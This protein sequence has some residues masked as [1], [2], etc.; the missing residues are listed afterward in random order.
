MTATVSERVGTSPQFVDVSPYF[1]LSHLPIA[2]P[3]SARSPLECLQGA[4]MDLLERENQ[5]SVLD[6]ALSDTR[7]GH[8]R[9]A[10]VSGEAGIGKTALLRAFLQGID[11]DGPRTPRILRGACENLSVAEPLAPLY[12]LSRDVGWQPPASLSGGEGRLALFSDA[13]SEFSSWAP[14]TILVIEDLHWADEATLDFVRFLAR[15]I[16]DHPILFLATA[17]NDGSDAQAQL[18]RA[19]GEVPP[20]ALLRVG[21]PPLSK[22]AVDSLARAAGRDA[23]AV[24]D[25]TKGNAFFVTELLHAEGDAP[26]PSVQDAVLARAE[27]LSEPARAVLD[28]ASVFPRRA[29]TGLVADIIGEAAEEGIEECLDRGLLDLDGSDLLFRHELARIA[30]EGALRTP[31]RRRLNSDLYSFLTEAGAPAARRL[32]HAREAGLNEVVRDLAPRAAEAAQALGARREAAA[33]YRVSVNAVGEDASLDLLETA[34][35]ANYYVGRYDAAVEYQLRVQDGLAGSNDPIREGDGLRRL[36]RFLWTGGRQVDAREYAERAVAHL[37]GLE[38]GELAHALSNLSQLMMLSSF[39]EDAV[40]ASEKAIELAKRFDRPDVVA[41]AL[42][43][44]GGARIFTNMEFA[45]R[46]IR[47]S[48]ELSLG[49]GAAD[50]AARAMCN[51]AYVEWW[52][53][54]YS[55]GYD[56]STGYLD[57]MAEQELDGYFDYHGGT[58]ALF[59]VELA[60]FEEAERLIAKTTAPDDETLHGWH[61]FPGTVANVRYRMRRGQP[62][63]PVA[64]RYLEIFRERATESQRFAPLT[65]L[66]AERVWI[67]GGD[68]GPIIEKMV[69]VIA[70]TLRPESIPYMRVWLHRFGAGDR[71]CE[72][73]DLVPV[74]HRK[75]MEGDHLGAAA[76][77]A[78]RNAPYNEAF[79]L[80]FSG[81]SEKVREAAAIFERLGAA[82]HAK[83]ALREIGADGTA[84]TAASADPDALTRRQMD[85]LRCLTEGKSNAQIGEALFISSKTVDHHVS[86]ILA[87]LGAANR[88]EAAAIARDR[89]LV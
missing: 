71:D 68:T 81:I 10:L 54:N 19:L 78:D 28:A 23:G 40:P 33:H 16:A 66:E 65:E 12:D 24:W 51:V 13:L 36:S 15:R 80:A 32:H 3:Y 55:E 67:E 41:H 42:N 69:D 44:L 62:S 77:W 89:G 74:A 2:V 31:R 14:G 37:E 48:I 17:R 7:A 76:I 84:R 50:E 22:E 88:G 85:V 61:K 26:P 47:E 72:I 73:T 52:H 29:E 60:R 8:G 35:M 64:D 25:A 63:D 57:Y 6:A 58:L 21:V 86:A 5:L 43:N 4:V 39:G 9:V 46:S 30:V 20:S 27:R 70:R 38:C 53:Q 1:A 34:A 11:T 87:K 45:R 49:I 75:E 83:A 82:A 18:R 79:A 59:A 56:A